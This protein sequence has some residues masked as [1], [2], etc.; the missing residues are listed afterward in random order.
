MVVHQAYLWAVRDSM[1]VMD[2]A[3]CSE[4][5]ILAVEKFSK[6]QVPIDIAEIMLDVHALKITHLQINRLR[7]REYITSRHV[8]SNLLM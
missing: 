1:A 3:H 2:R 6:V 4:A 7:V 8:F 5:T